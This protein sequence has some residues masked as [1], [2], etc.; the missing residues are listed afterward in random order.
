VLFRSRRFD[1]SEVF[2]NDN[3]G[4]VKTLVSALE[5]D[6]LLYKEHVVRR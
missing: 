2:R 6:S 4:P 3:Y 5:P 1:I